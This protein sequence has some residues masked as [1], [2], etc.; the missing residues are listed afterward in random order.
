MRRSQEMEFL[1]WYKH[2]SYESAI[3]ARHKRESENSGETMLKIFV[4]QCVV[5]YR[6]VRNE[7]RA[8]VEILPDFLNPHTN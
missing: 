8:L 7:I 6:H 5:Y 2:F 4:K 3:H 1:L